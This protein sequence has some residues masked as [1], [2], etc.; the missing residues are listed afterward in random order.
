[1]VQAAPP[2]QGV[3]G[4]LVTQYERQFLRRVDAPGALEKTLGRSLGVFI[5]DAIGRAIG[6]TRT[7]A[8][9]AAPPVRLVIA[10][11][12]DLRWPLRVV[13]ALVHIGRAV[14]EEGVRA[15]S[16]DIKV[17][18]THA[19]G[20][21]LVHFSAQLNVYLWDMGC[22]SGLLR[23]CLGG[24]RGYQGVCRVYLVSETAQFELRRRR[25]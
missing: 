7:V 25:V 2:R 17:L 6:A 15:I 13:S 24:V 14:L 16:C 3:R 19:S 9:N 10:G 18:H 8:H 23:R 4:T 1:M 22:I 21:D 11:V 12:R 20:A 5:D